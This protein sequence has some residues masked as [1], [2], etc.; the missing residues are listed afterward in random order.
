[1][2]ET[3]DRPIGHKPPTS[4]RRSPGGWL[5]AAAA[6]AVVG[7]VGALLVAAAGDD[8]EINVPATAP[9]TTAPA[10]DIMGLPEGLAEIEPGR[11]FIDPDGD[12]TTPLRVTYEVAAEGWEPWIGAVKFR[13]GG[14]AG[15]SITTV[16]NVVTDGCTDHD[17]LVPPVGPTVDDLATALTQL[18][19]FRVTA[20]PTDVTLFG[21]PGK[22]LTLTVPAD[23]RVADDGDDRTFPDCSDGELHSWI[24]PLLDGSFWGYLGLPS[25]TEEFWILDVGGTRLVLVKLTSPSTPAQDI[26]QR[27]AMFDSI[28]IEP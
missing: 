15:F 3:E 8:D 2:L 17:P 18:P 14:H 16:T 21:Y 24:A 22:H 25:M 13:D 11:Y 1:M 26:T 28:R 5:L 6:V 23:L 7:V 20:A 27:D 19:P 12:P 4:R 9:P 10:Q